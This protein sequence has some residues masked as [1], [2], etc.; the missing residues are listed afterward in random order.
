MITLSLILVYVPVDAKGVG[1]CE[2]ERHRQSLKHH[3]R[4]QKVLGGT[5]SPLYM[6]AGSQEA[7]NTKKLREKS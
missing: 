7:S 6:T 3:A 4:I 1:K 5:V 2:G